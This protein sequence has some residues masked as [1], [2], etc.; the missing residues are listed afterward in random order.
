MPLAGFAPLAFLLP[1]SA[2]EYVQAC[3]IAYISYCDT[4]VYTY[5]YIYICMIAYISY[6]DTYVYTYIY[7]HM[8][9]CMYVCM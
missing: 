3:M 5:I 7:T 6:C 2:S 9:V 1:H 8:Y 4:Y